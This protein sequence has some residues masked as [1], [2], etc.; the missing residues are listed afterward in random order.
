MIKF[1][2]GQFANILILVFL[3][4]VVT[5]CATRGSG[6]SF[7]FEETIANKAVIYHYRPSSFRGSAIQ[8]DVLSNGKPLTRIGN[9]GYFKEVSEPGRIIYQTKQQGSSPVGFVLIEVGN[10]LAK[11]KKAYELDVEPG[12][13]YFLKWYVELTKDLPLITQEPYDKAIKEIGGLLSFQPAELIKDEK[14]SE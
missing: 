8:W 5:G 9:G 11:Y 7:V 1:R 14:A 10:V 13:Y 12:K 4:V 2:F 3:A 6:P